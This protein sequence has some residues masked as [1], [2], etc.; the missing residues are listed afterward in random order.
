MAGWKGKLLSSSGKE[1]LIKAVAQAIAT[2]IMSYFQLPK[3]LCDELE[4]MMR[5]F[6]WGQKNQ[7]SKIAWISWRK[8]CK[9]KSLGGLGFRNLQA[10]NLALLAKQAWRILTNPSSLAARILKVKYFPYCDVISASLGS[11]PS[12][13]WRSIHNSLEVLRRGTR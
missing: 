7:E 6:W 8:M 10:F 1:I 2:Y 3:S 9:P 5:N 11:N 12:Y 4:K 13:T